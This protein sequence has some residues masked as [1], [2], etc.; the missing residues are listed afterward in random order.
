MLY[1]HIS[2]CG[3]VGNPAHGRW[4]GTRWSLSFLPTQSILSFYDSVF[5]IIPHSYPSAYL[6]SVRQTQETYASTTYLFVI[7]DILAYGISVFPNLGILTPCGTDLD[8]TSNS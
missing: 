7:S 2:A 8:C 5:Y 6:Q 3:L 4:V 1:I